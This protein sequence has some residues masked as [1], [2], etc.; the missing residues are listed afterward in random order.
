MSFPRPRQT[1]ISVSIALA[2]MA[3]TSIAPAA[4]TGLSLIHISEPTRPY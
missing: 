1:A 2:A 4:Q 3:Y